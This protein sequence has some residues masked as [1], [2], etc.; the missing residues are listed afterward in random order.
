M[1]IVWSS[2]L[3]GVFTM[4]FMSCEKNLND[5]PLPR[6]KVSRTVLVYI[7][8]DNGSNELSSLLRTNFDDM[9]V[10]MESVNDD[11]CN[12]IVYSELVRDTPHLIQIQK[13]NGVVI[14]DT[15]YSYQEQN[16]LNAQVM[17]QVVEETVRLFPADSYG[18]VFLSHSDA[19]LEAKQ[20]ASRSVSQYSIGDYRGTQMNVADFKYVLQNSFPKPLEFILFDSCYM[21]AIEVAYELRNCANFIIASP[22][23]IPGPGAPYLTLTPVLFAEANAEML[24]AQIYFDTYSLNYKSGVAEEYDSY[25]KSYIWRAGVSVSVIDTKVLDK[26]AVATRNIL[27]A[28]ITNQ[29][30]VGISDIMQYSVGSSRPYYD[31]DNFIAKLTADNPELYTEWRKVFDE[32]VVY[33]NTT[34]TNYFSNNLRSMAGSAGVSMYIPQGSYSSTLNNFY[35]TYDWYVDSGWFDTGW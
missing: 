4:L 29:S 18:F 6:S 21:Q 13:R 27:P 14:A 17:S 16:P 12:L 32:A 8:G 7:V 19:W 34:P 22:T 11:D 5:E 9:L 30:V 3:V 10:G 26:L 23:E 24:I 20:P 33:W 1:R 31:F 35:R 25:L 2:L 28:F 15:L